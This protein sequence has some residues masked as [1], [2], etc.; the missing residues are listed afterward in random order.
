MRRRPAL[1]LA[2]VAAVA[3]LW[4]GAAVAHDHRPPRAHVITGTDRARMPRGSYQWSEKQGRFCSTVIADAFLVSY[5]NAADYT[6]GD[7]IRIRFRKHHRPDDVDIRQY[8]EVKKN[9]QPKGDGRQKF[10]VLGKR[11][12]HGNVRWEARFELKRPGHHYFDVSASWKDVDNCGYQTA[13][14]STHVK[15]IRS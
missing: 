15:A 7:R 4:P 6:I 3:A 11:I 1:V 13:L 9:G 5:P 2:G 14:W 12:V 8:R 10:F